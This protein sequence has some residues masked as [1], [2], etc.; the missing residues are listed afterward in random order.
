MNTILEEATVNAPSVVEAE[1]SNGKDSLR[2]SRTDRIARSISQSFS[3]Q[4]VDTRTVNIVEYEPVN[5]YIRESIRASSFLQMSFEPLS[6]GSSRASRG[7]G[8]HRHTILTILCYTF[9]AFGNVIVDEIYNVWAV[10]RPER[11]LGFNSRNIGITW[12]V[13]GAMDVAFQG[14]VFGWLERKLG[15]V[16]IFQ[17]SMACSIPAIAGLPFLTLLVPASDR[18]F[19]ASWSDG[20]LVYSESLT[21]EGSFDGLNARTRIDIWLALFSLMAV[22]TI[23][24]L[25]AYTTIMVL[26][27]N[28]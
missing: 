8:P 14:L 6:L 3:R 9:L 15:A 26:V 2:L 25:C 17:W 23:S 20:Q 11:G 16:R 27:R 10:E 5:T 13:L 18:H 1:P 7:F 19:L 21:S 22:K 12:T 28:G 4:I 24:Q